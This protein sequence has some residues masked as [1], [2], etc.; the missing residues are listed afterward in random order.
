ME[1]GLDP[2]H[3][4]VDGDP[5]PTKRGTA[6]LPTFRLMSATAELL[7]LQSILLDSV[8]LQSVATYPVLLIVCW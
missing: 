3:I 8:E 4:V 7:S 2:D 1:V 5:A 6:A